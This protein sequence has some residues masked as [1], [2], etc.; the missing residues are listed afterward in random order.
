MYRGVLF[1]Q[2]TEQTTEGSA[3]L[4]SIY[5]YVLVCVMLCVARIPLH[6]GSLYYSFAGWLSLHVPMCLLVRLLTARAAQQ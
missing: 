6:T 1:E 2:M 4:L 3:H 5:L